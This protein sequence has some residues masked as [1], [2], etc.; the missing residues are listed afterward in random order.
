MQHE[1]TSLYAD[2]LEAEALWGVE[3]KKMFKVLFALQH[4]LWSCTRQHLILLNPDTSAA[5]KEAIQKRHSKGRDILYAD[6]GEESDEFK[7]EFMVGV[8]SIENL[9]KPKL[10]H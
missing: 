10:T 7:K 3:L 5:K 9:L 1:C 4:E 6:P 8:E 2:L